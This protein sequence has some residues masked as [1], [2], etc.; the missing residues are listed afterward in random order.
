MSNKIMSLRTFI[1][2]FALLGIIEGAAVV[3]TFNTAMLQFGFK[4]ESIQDTQF[5]RGF[6]TNLSQT[7]NINSSTLGNPYLNKT[8]GSNPNVCNVS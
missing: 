8:N 4:W 5:K 7:F 2:S 3:F 1:I 6:K